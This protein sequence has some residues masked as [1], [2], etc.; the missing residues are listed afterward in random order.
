MSQARRRCTRCGTPIIL[1]GPRQS[2]VNFTRAVCG[3]FGVA[4]SPLCWGCYDRARGND[5]TPRARAAAEREAKF[6]GGA[7]G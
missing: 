1:G 4:T 7:R 3:G 5:Q 2:G 6:D